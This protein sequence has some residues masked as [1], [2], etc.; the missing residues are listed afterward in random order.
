MSTIDDVNDARNKLIGAEVAQRVAAYRF[1]VSYS[2]LHAASGKMNDFLT[3]FDR[4][5]WVAQK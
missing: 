2:L 1:V 4:A 5:D 3:V